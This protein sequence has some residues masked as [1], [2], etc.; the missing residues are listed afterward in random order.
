MLINFGEKSPKSWRFYSLILL[1]WM[2]TGIQIYLI[3]HYSKPQLDENA[4]ENLIFQT[5]YHYKTRSINLHILNQFLEHFAN[6]V[7]PSIRVH[8]IEI[9][10]DLIKVYGKTENEK[11]FSQFWV[12]FKRQQWAQHL[13][14]LQWEIQSTAQWLFAFQ[15]V[16]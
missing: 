15:V 5:R 11:V 7:P 6:W 2:A 4:L 1:I 9:S 14:L 16:L 12:N 10:S 8:K 3:V 13:N